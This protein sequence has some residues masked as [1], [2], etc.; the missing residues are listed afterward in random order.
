MS[1]RV[2]A[3]VAVLAVALV[4]CSRA[5]PDASSS[6][7]T[8]RH[9]LKDGRWRETPV[10]PRRSFTPSGGR[11]G[12]YISN[13]DEAV[14]E[15]WY[16]Q[17][18]ASVLAQLAAAEGG[19]LEYS[20]KQDSADAGFPDDDVVIVG[21]RGGCRTGSTTRRAP[22]GRT[23]PCR[24]PRRRTGAGTGTRAPR[25]SRSTACSAVRHDW[26][27]AANTAPATTRAGW[28]ISCSR[29]GPAASVSFA[30]ASRTSRYGGILPCR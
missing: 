4:S 28:I 22:S 14:G 18:P 8:S 7:T 21:R 16:F 15:T 20:L 29:P 23:S 6:S 1:R 2:N 25:R 5:R 3:L 19:R 24:S 9:R 27:F 30:K 13:T 12:G 10:R 11:S 26:R 17:A